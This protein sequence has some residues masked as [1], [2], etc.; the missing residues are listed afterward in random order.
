MV[1]DVAANRGAPPAR[2]S[3][4]RYYLKSSRTILLAGT[5]RVPALAPHRRSGGRAHLR[6]PAGT[7]GGQYAV[8]ACVDATRRVRERHERN[9]C[10]AARGRVAVPGPDG[11]VPPSK[12]PSP[13]RSVD[14]DHD[15]YPDGLDCA[16]RDASVHPGATDMPDLHF[17]DANCDGI[18]G[19]LETAVFVSPAGND[20]NPGTMTRPLRTLAAAIAAADARDKD[21][22]AAAGVYPEELR[23]ASRVSVYGGYGESW[24]RSLSTPTRITG[25]TVSGGDTE[26]A[27]AINITA[28]T[29][30]QLVTLAPNAPS[31]PGATSYG[32]RGI[33]SAGGLEPY[34]GGRRGRRRPR[35]LPRR[36]PGRTSRQRDIRLRRLAQ[37]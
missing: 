17:V 26:A 21:V 27:L 3:L 4:T 10:R 30:L 12:P 35:A 25:A 1:G 22:Y 33:H 18:D 13:L 36:R 37:P 11:A 8:V 32:L 19:D 28:P 15:G 20:A 2:R 29:T 31:T 9:N 24:K 5:R 34:H 14:S 16:P 6:I 7:P 23:L